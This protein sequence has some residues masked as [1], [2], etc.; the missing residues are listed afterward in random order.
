MSK[1]TLVLDE[2]RMAAI[3]RMRNITPDAKA[4]CMDG[5]V[6]FI[7]DLIRQGS[8]VFT[9]SFKIVINRLEVKFQDDKAEILQYVFN[10]I[11]YGDVH[12]VPIPTLVE[13]YSMADKY[14]VI[15]LCNAIIMCLEVIANTYPIEIYRWATYP[16]LNDI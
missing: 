6:P 3:K 2:H 11:Q 7:F 5:E 16:P 4:I 13:V 15:G 8:E 14:R 1:R 9:E 10:Y 12:T